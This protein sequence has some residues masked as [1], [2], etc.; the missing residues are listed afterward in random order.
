MDSVMVDS[1][2]GGEAFWFIVNVSG[3]C[4]VI[5]LLVLAVVG[6]VALFSE[7]NK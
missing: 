1:L 7:R 2:G 4:L 3:S 5:G 6:I